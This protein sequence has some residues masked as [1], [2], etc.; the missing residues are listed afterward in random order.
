MPIRR[1]RALAAL[2]VLAVGL[3]LAAPAPA[4]AASL[5]LHEWDFNACDQYGRSNPDCQVTPTQRAAAISSSIT[6]FGAQVVT[7]QEMCRSTFDMV[8][9]ALPAGWVSAFFS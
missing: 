9:G 8:V 6:S 7:L 3:G 5:R 2:F 1:T 4:S